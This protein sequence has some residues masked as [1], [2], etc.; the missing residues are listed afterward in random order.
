MLALFLA[1]AFSFAGA[2]AASDECSSNVSSCSTGSHGAVLIQREHRVE[3]AMDEAMDES[4]DEEWGSEPRC[5][6]LN[7]KAKTDLTVNAVSRRK[8]KADFKCLDGRC[9]WFK[10]QKKE[11]N[12]AG[13]PTVVLIRTDWH[14]QSLLDYRSL[15]FEGSAWDSRKSYKSSRWWNPL[16]LGVH[17]D[18]D[19]HPN[20]AEFAFRVHKTRNWDHPRFLAGDGK[21]VYLARVK[22][23]ETIPPEAIWMVSAI[24][25]SFSP[26]EVAAMA[27]AAPV[28]I[29]AAAVTG[30]VAAAGV[31]G[32]TAGWVA[33]AAV[34]AGVAAGGAALKGPLTA[35]V[36]N[37]YFVNW[38]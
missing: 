23:N 18:K 38:W 22:A 20:M 24:G 31:A 32:I 10:L 30:G 13:F 27:F 14:P 26:G 21:R 34:T 33:T 1:L 37:S 25:S 36:A 35:E 17:T 28:G 19:A 4:M 11:W 7:L 16:L 9:N 5:R 6:L 29:V 3:Q 15:D 2:L 12:A 8:W